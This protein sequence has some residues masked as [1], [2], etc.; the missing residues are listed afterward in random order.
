VS[1]VPSKVV[2]LVFLSKVVNLVF[3]VLL[4]WVTSVSVK[5][6]TS[7]VPCVRTHVQVVIILIRT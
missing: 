6:N 2:I 4:W 3:L 7:T 5:D 1:L